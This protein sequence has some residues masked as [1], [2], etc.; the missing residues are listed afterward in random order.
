MEFDEILES[1]KSDLENIP[2]NAIS[3]KLIQK[4][5]RFGDLCQQLPKEQKQDALQKA[6]DIIRKEKY[7]CAIFMYSFFSSCIP[8]AK[9]M[10]ELLETILEVR[11]IDADILY[12]LYWQIAARFMRQPECESE[13]GKVK[14]WKLFQCIC[15]KYE[16]IFPDLKW[17]DESERNKNLIVVIASQFLD[18]TVHG[19]TK[20][21]LDRCKTL[22]KVLH[23][24][25]L[26]INTAEALSQIGNIPFFGLYEPN[27]REELCS[28]EY[29]EWQNVN[30]PFFQCSNDMP[31]LDEM[32]VLIKQII[33]LKPQFV[34]EIGT[35]SILANLVSKCLPVLSVN[36]GFSRLAVTETQCQLSMLQM[37]EKEQRILKQVGKRENHVISGVFTFGLKSQQGKLT[38]EQLGL[39][40]NKFLLAVVGMRLAE[41]I[42]ASFMGML[43]SI[44]NK[45]IAVVYI[46]QFER[47]EQFSQ[48]YSDLEVDMYYL[49]IQEDVL[50]VLEVCDLFVNPIRLG[51]GTSAAEALTKGL[52]VVSTSYGDIGATIG[53]EFWVEDYTEMA[54]EINR[55]QKDPIFYKRQSELAKNRAQ[56]LLDTDGEFVR[57]IG[58]FGKRIGEDYLS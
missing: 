30:I 41:E 53:E 4:V 58:E 10:E 43:N 38:R 22:I 15:Q 21:A 45:Q 57:A 44:K 28:E 5:I 13:K 11:D 34:I 31:N 37:T 35:G 55:Y 12:F 1:I 14:H 19:P 51:G 32:N 18:A 2:N 24:K 7:V 6:V 3:E 49:G 42:D 39:P 33:Q 46:G 29:I 20:T 50:A 16:K 48:N 52:P 47:F 9:W 25:V 23:K 8:K 27:Y 54:K 56:R 36:T 26:L 17:I 40:D